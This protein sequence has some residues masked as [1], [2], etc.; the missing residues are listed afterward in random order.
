MH[1]AMA[2]KLISI[3]AHTPPI[4]ARLS[5]PDWIRGMAAARARMRPIMVPALAIR[6]MKGVV[7]RTASAIRGLG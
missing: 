4:A 5:N 6:P 3:S 7:C 2:T 1:A